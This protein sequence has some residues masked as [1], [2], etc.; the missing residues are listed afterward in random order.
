VLRLPI[1]ARPLRGYWWLP[2]SRG[3]VLRVLRGTYEPEQ[4]AHFLRWV[5]PGATVIDIGAHVGYYTLL[6]SMLAGETGSVW[7]FE[8]EPTNAAFLRR[9]TYLNNC[10]NVHVEELAVSNSDGNARF[11]C[12]KGSGTGHLDQTG[13]MEVRTVRLTE[14]CAERGISPSALKIDVEGAEA[15]VLEGAKELILKSR[16]VIFLSTHGPAAHAHCLE[17]LR[18]AGYSLRPI[19]GGRI[20]D[21]AEILALPDGAIA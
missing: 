10:R 8:P 4:T 1:M 18:A 7:A 20:E 13:D 3:K 19:L 14:F 21:A 6:A 9:H 12:G 5:R 15:A 17:W 11:L 2:T 16:P